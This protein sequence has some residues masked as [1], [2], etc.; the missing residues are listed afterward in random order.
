MASLL[1]VRRHLSDLKESARQVA[2]SAPP[3]PGVDVQ[4]SGSSS[5]V[6]LCTDAVSFLSGQESEAFEKRNLVINYVVNYCIR[7][8]A[9]TDIIALI[10]A[11]QAAATENDQLGSIGWDWSNWPGSN[12]FTTSPS[13]QSTT[14]D[15]WQQLF[16]ELI[17]YDDND[18]S[19]SVSPIHTTESPISG[20]TTEDWFEQFIAELFPDEEVSPTSSSPITPRSTTEDFALEDA[21]NEF[22]NLIEGEEEGE[23]EEEENDEEE[24]GD[25]Q[26]EEE[27]GDGQEEDEEDE[28]TLNAL[29][30]LLKE[31]QGKE[32]E[33]E[34][35]LPTEE[36]VE[37]DEDDEDDDGSN[38]LPPLDINRRMLMKKRLLDLLSKSLLR[39]RQEMMR[40]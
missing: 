12:I 40:K 37:D 20:A 18:D 35:T 36:I 26:K 19:T 21:F 29:L 14:L 13:P 32:T 34:P 17:K 38:D 4:E 31:E 8:S 22:W 24:E 7:P 6:Q 30:G 15:Y 16:D 10:Q 28:D 2:T 11:L 1:Q 33:V 5:H 25:D 39:K 9:T 3:T 27:Q 23:T